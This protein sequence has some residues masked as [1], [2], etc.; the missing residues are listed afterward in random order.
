MKFS[1][2]RVDCF[3]QCPYKYKLRYLDGLK[4]LPDQS[5][6]NP[7]YLGT[8]IHLAFETGDVQRAIDEYRSNYYVLSDD[9]INETTKLE[10]LIPKVLEILPPAECEVE[11]STEDFVGYIDRLVPLPDTGDGLKHYEIWDYK[12]ANVKSRERYMNSK[13]LHIYK[14]YFEKTHPN[15]IVDALR[16][17]FIPKISIRQK[18]DETVQAFR[19]RL[20][21]EID[22]AK[23]EVVEVPFDT[24][25]VEEFF[26]DTRSLSSASDFPK[27]QTR[28]CDFCEFSS[29]CWSGDDSNFLIE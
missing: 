8:A 11:I 3:L 5:A 10:G 7:L 17:V 14:W 15:T 28:L 23:I 16:Y 13:Q 19:A 18:K 24:N 22:N 12:Y 2:S 6:Q 4:T 29:Y 9:I 27:N 21:E 20:R 26:S 25:K 1:Y